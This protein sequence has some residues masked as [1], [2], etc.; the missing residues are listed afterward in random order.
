MTVHKVSHDLLQRWNIDGPPAQLRH[1][2]KTPTTWLQGFVE[3]VEKRVPGQT[4]R[5]V[6]QDLKILIESSADLRMLASAMLDEI[7]NKSPYKENPVGRRQVRNYTHM[8]QLFSVIVTEVA[9]TW[10]M[11]E[12]GVGLLGLPFTA[13]LAWPMATPS[14]YA[15]FLRKDVNEKLKAILNTWRDDILTTSKSLHVLTAAED[16][17]LCK[18]SLAALEQDG[19]A[20]YGA[21]YSFSE[22]FFMYTGRGSCALGVQIVRPVGHRNKPEWV[23]S[24]CEARPYALQTNVKAYDSVWLKGNRYSVMEMLDHH[25]LAESFIGG[26]VFQSFHTLTSYHRWCAP[27]SGHVIEVRVVDGTYFS[28][29]TFT[30]SWSLVR[31]PLNEKA[32]AGYNGRDQAALVLRS[33]YSR[34]SIMIIAVPGLGAHPHHTWEARQTHEPNAADYQTEQPTRVHLLKDLLAH[35]FPEARILNFA[36]DSNWLINAPVKTTEE[37]GKCLLKEIKDKRSLPHLLIIFIGHSLG[38]IIIK[39]ALCGSGS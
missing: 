30:G 29:A 39:Q 23:V 35:D 37:I 12:Y 2:S 18:A 17:W 34:T 1:N 28:E 13:I 25:E 22:L 8:L 5:P 36:H 9:P 38:G 6:V 20:E 32:C 10:D 33:L 19:N 11:A 21:R 15:F 27:V 16:G 7:P 31:H 3:N 26:T 4:L 24:A 14:G